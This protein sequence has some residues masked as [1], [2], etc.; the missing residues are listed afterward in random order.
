MLKTCEGH[1][2]VTFGLRCAASWLLQEDSGQPQQ[3]VKP[4][5]DASASA[6]PAAAEAA[7]GGAPPGKAGA[8]THGAKRAAAS[9]PIR[10]LLHP[11]ASKDVR[12]VGRDT[13]GGQT[14]GTRRSVATL[15]VECVAQAA[16]PDTRQVPCCVVV[17]RP[18][19]GPNAATG[20][21]QVLSYASAGYPRVL[22]LYPGPT[23]H[24]D[25]DGFGAF[26]S[27]AGAAAGVARPGV[28]VRE[29]QQAA[30]GGR[31]G[32]R[33]R[34]VAAARAG[35]AGERPGAGLGERRR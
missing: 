31:W 33:A 18:P 16:C 34:G 26:R 32:T 9:E 28:R 21:I 17:L 11:V 13:C 12:K 8:P 3:E 20:I 29:A 30:E 4:Q 25:G 2:V 1:T 23:A 14:A 19:R 27:G 7:G 24:E 6:A 15:A 35:A 10:I 5:P 22:P